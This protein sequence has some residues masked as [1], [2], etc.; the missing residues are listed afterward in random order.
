MQNGSLNMAEVELPLKEKVYNEIGK[1][2]SISISALTGGLKCNRDA[3]KYAITELKKEE[4]I[5]SSGR[6]A[7][8]VKTF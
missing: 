5:E 6:G 2:E 3:L 8:K 7:Y 4:R 1:F